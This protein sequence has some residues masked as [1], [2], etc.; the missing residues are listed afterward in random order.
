MK[1]L[2]LENLKPLYDEIEDALNSGAE[3]IAAFDADGTLWDTDAGENFFKYLDEKSLVELPNNAWEY[4]IEWHDREPVASFLWLAQI[5]K[6]LPLTVVQEF[7]TAG[8]THFGEMPVFEHQRKLIAFLKSKGV[9]V[10]IVTASVKWA[11]EPA[12][13]LFGLA[14]ED[15]IGIQ[16]EVVDG[17]VTDKQAGPI[18]WRE[19]KVDGILEA[20]G[21]KKPFFA[22]GNTTGD[23]FL[24][25]CAT[26]I[27][28]AHCAAKPG[29]LTHRTEV[30]LLAEAEKRNW[31]RLRV[32]A[33]L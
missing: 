19:G 25:E 16:T 33:S 31:F 2:T 32:P 22:A 11:V 24:L 5:C 15:V 18:T 8:L 3:P 1:E 17:I 26:H 12:A 21:G 6:G 29:E 28:Y 30:D 13:E 23:L 4:Y 7:A 9:K 14:P 20:T 27:A 10:Y